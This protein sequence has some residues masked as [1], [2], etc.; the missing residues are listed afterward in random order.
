MKYQPP[1]ITMKTLLTVAFFLSAFASQSQSNSREKMGMV[2]NVALGTSRG[3]VTHGWHFDH[4]DGSDVDIIFPPGSGVSVGGGVGLWS[5]RF[6]FELQLD[7]AFL[8]SYVASASGSSGMETSGY[9]FHKTSMFGIG[10]LKFPGKKSLLY[11]RV[12]LGPWLV[13]PGNFVLKI[14]GDEV[15]RAVYQP[16][17]GG[18]L[19]GN[20]VIQVQ[21]VCLIPGIRF[22]IG[23][24]VSDQYIL[25]AGLLNLFTQSIGKKPR[26]LHFYQIPISPA[27]V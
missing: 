21:G 17:I 7:Q 22:K 1:P 25:C 6:D 27:D 8:L 2:V 11:S 20:L 13:M 19:D 16:T 5:K 24:A 18:V 10:Y 3:F 12:G 26:N 4:H 23:Q 9:R 14:N 15:G